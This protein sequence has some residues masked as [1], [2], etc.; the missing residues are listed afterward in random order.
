MGSL[1]IYHIFFLLSRCYI[2]L[3]FYSAEIEFLPTEITNLDN[4]LNNSW[5]CYAKALSLEDRDTEKDSLHRRVGNICN[6]LGS[7]YMRLAKGK[8]IF[9]WL[10]EK[11]LRANPNSVFAE[12]RADKNFSKEK[13]EALFAIS[14]THLENGIKAFKSVKDD[15]NLALLYSNTG[16][17]MRVMAHFYSEDGSPLNKVAKSFYTKVMKTII[18]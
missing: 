11:Y 14:I 1:I 7:Y 3:L 13:M 8:S 5:M 6:E 4:I 16:H 2:S 9:F 18:Y 10:I 15:G 12:A 17:L